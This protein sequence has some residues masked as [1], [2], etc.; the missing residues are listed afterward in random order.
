[1]SI[2]RILK[3]KELYFT[4]LPVMLLYP[5]VVGI[6]IGFTINRKKPEENSLNVYSN[7]I[8]YAGL[9]IITGITYPISYPF[10]GCYV[11]YKNSKY[12]YETKKI[13]PN[14]TISS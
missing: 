1:M 8:G 11:L 9:G 3:Y 10:F 14:E 4:V 5:T 12:S 13:V 6:D 2:A 7:L